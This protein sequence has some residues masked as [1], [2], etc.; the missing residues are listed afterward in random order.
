M[1]PVVVIPTVL[2]TLRVCVIGSGGMPTCEAGVG[3]EFIQCGEDAP[4]ERQDE[5]DDAPWP[6]CREHLPLPP[7]PDALL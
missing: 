5:G 1:R 3:E 6:C 4:Y 2:A 7:L